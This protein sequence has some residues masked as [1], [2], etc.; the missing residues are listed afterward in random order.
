V[1]VQ[2]RTGLRLAAEAGRDAGQEGLTRARRG[3]GKGLRPTSHSVRWQAHTGWNEHDHPA[4]RQMLI[5]VRQTANASAGHDTA[6][7]AA[8]PRRQPAGV[9]E[10]GRAHQFLH[11]LEC[12]D[13]AA[14]RAAHLQ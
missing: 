1:G 7:A 11:A 3:Y 13:A 10:V 2:G 8:R 14:L 4:P 12:S 9:L 5:P 6:A